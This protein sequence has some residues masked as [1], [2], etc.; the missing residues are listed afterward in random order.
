MFD[1][2]TGKILV[3]NVSEKWSGSLFYVF[4]LSLCISFGFLLFLLLFVLFLL[5]FYFSDFSH[6][7]FFF[8][9]SALCNVSFCLYFFAVVLF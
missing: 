5:L 7:E 2:E 3:K 6:L 4:F 1:K 8:L 9:I